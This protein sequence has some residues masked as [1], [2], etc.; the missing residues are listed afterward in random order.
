[1]ELAGETWACLGI[2]RQQCVCSKRFPTTAVGAVLV[3]QRSFLTGCQM[4]SLVLCMGFLAPHCVFS[5]FSQRTPEVDGAHFP[6]SAVGA[7]LVAQRSFL[8]GSGE[9]RAH[10]AHGGR[11]ALHHGGPLFPGGQDQLGP[12]LRTH[13]LLASN[14]KFSW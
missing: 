3:A 9:V 12:T 2:A 6:M 10:A 8:A 13:T 5:S 7:V 11:R 1:M 4:L 14:K